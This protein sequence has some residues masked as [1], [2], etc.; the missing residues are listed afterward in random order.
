MF[1]PFVVLGAVID[2]A[3]ALFLLIVVGWILD[4]WNDRDPW[5]GPVSTALWL[6]S[7]LLCVSGPVVAYHLKRRKAA[8]GAVLVAVWMPSVMLTV[9]TTIGFIIFTP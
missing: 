8:P 6:A 4:S 3:M 1:R 5:M 2:I 9:L 7:F